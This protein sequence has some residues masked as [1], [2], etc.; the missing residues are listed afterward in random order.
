MDSSINIV[1]FSLK[2]KLMKQVKVD[3][4]RDPYVIIIATRYKCFFSIPGG[5]G[6][7]FTSDFVCSVLFAITTLCIQNPPLKIPPLQKIVILNLPSTP[8]SVTLNGRSIDV[9]QW[10]YDTI[11]KAIIVN[12]LDIM[13]DES[14]E[15]RWMWRRVSKRGGAQMHTNWEK[16]EKV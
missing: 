4:S 7:C 5:K 3:G 8:L 6:D 15:L 12:E 9:A 2:P 13:I 1:W 11:R 10:M 16:I 14:F